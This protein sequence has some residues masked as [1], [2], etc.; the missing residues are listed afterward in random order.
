LILYRRVDMSP[1]W[2]VLGQVVACS[3]GKIRRVFTAGV[4]LEPAVT[5]DTVREL[6]ALHDHKAG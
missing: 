1:A 4:I 6:A 3:H 2:P 5:A